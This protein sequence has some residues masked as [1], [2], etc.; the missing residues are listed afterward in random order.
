[1]N[2]QHGIIRLTD[3]QS[4][5]SCKSIV[6]P[7]VFLRVF[8]VVLRQSAYNLQHG[9]NRVYASLASTAEELLNSAESTDVSRKMS[10]SPG[11]GSG[12]VTFYCCK[13]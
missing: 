6:L 3:N 13:L 4:V 5:S 1:M 11:I 8:E 10:A 12:R 2:V 7:E 9:R